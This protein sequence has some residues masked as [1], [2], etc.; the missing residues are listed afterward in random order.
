MFLDAYT[1]SAF[2]FLFGTS[3]VAY[4]TL[5]TFILF[6]IGGFWTIF[7]TYVYPDLFFSGTFLQ[8]FDVLN[9]FVMLR[10]LQKVA[11]KD[12]AQADR[13]RRYYGFIL[14]D[15]KE[16]ADSMYAQVSHLGKSIFDS[17]K[18]I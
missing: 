4:L 5:A 16:W 17:R 11:S 8:G 3:V 14:N 7:A 15:V 9:Y 12:N 10:F 18:N 6:T 1:R 13:V 2:E